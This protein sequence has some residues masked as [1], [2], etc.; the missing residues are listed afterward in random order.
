MAA[1]ASALTAGAEHLKGYNAAHVFHPFPNHTVNRE[2]IALFDA[3]EPGV[4]RF[5]GGT[6]ANKY[7]FYK[8]G[9]GF[10]NADM[11]R[12]ENYIVEF[13]R[14]V[15]AMEKPPRVVFVMNLFEHFTGADEAALI[16][17][18]LDALKYLIDQGMDVT[19]VELG[20]EFYLYPEITL[21]SGKVTVNPEKNNE[22]NAPGNARPA[23]FLVRW[24]RILTGRFTGKPAGNTE[25]VRRNFVYY[26]DLCKR[27]AA[28]IR[29]LDPGIRLGIPLG[30]LGNAKHDE[31]NE[32]VLG[33]FD[34]ID[35]YVC[36]FYGSFN[37]NCGQNDEACIRKGLDW[38]LKQQLETRLERVRQTGKEAW[39]TEWNGLKFG[40]YGD[41]G[42][43]LRNSAI[44][45]E[46][47]QKFIEAYDRYGVTISCF[48]KIAGPMENA[49]YNAIDV[50]NGKCYPT[51]VY[52]VLREH[53][54]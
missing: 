35:A 31:Y 19:A 7:H 28:S 24:L 48:H 2:A 30:N 9:Y 8:P 37:K 16:R 33:R 12:S 25:T 15:K 23:N 17:E 20:N 43:W 1:L 51:P 39:V 18:N 53:Y 34:F 45:L 40:H 14:I 50:D 54:R 47:I 38:Y 44:H 4:L 41:E 26:E 49:A 6:V 32:F 29:A 10:S 27:Y 13:V 21:G 22:V 5:P 52:G 46:Y 11:R 36:H 42:D 3:L